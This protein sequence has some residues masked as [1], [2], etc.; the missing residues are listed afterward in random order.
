VGS[1]PSTTRVARTVVPSTR[2]STATQNGSSK[3]TVIT[4]TVSSWQEAAA[5]LRWTS[6]PTGVGDGGYGPG[7]PTRR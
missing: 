3:K 7:G 2:S 5:I 4:G 6:V 1:A